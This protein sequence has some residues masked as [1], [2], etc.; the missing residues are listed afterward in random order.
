MA[1]GQMT[2]LQHLN[3]VEPHS[4]VLAQFRS[5]QPRRRAFS[6]VP[7]AASEGRREA[8]RRILGRRDPGRSAGSR[9][10]GSGE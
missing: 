8:A 2:G 6:R 1:A 10:G 9:L 3:L 5:A 4:H 7:L